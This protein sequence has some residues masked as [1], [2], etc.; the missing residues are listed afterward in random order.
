MQ[1][2]GKE[3][4]ERYMSNKSS[5]METGKQEQRCLQGTDCTDT[6]VKIMIYLISR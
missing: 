1:D 5:V 3:F 4:Q 2:K 6:Q